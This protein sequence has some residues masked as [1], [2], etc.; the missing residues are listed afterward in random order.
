MSAVSR[1]S[2]TSSQVSSSRRSRPSSASRPR[3]SAPWERASRARSR[4]SRPS[5]GARPVQG[6]PGQGLLEL[7]QVGF[8]DVLGQLDGVDTAQRGVPRD[9]GVIADA[10]AVVH[11]GARGWRAPAAAPGAAQ[12]PHDGERGDDGDCQGDDEEVHG[13]AVS[14]TRGGLRSSAVA[15]A[16]RRIADGAL[17]PQVDDPVSLSRPGAPLRCG[18]RPARVA[19]LVAARSDL[20][21]SGAHRGDG[22]LAAT[23]NRRPAASPVNPTGPRRSPRGSDQLA[24]PMRGPPGAMRSAADIDSGA[25]SAFDRSVVRPGRVR[26]GAAAIT[27]TQHP[28]IAMA[29]CTMTTVAIRTRCPTGATSAKPGGAAPPVNLRPGPADGVAG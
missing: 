29:S 5:P 7:G 4:M 27:S 18:L 9:L 26:A 21:D 24:P 19:R 3:P 15:R 16:V 17:V 12:Q 22:Q 2:S 8:G 14:Q 1:T 28:R 11:A 25:G 6:R 13:T 20:P 23:A 10:G